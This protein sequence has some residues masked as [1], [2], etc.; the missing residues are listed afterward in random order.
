MVSITQSILFTAI[1]NTLGQAT[2]RQGFESSKINV[3]YATALSCI[4]YG[5]LGVGML[6][7]CYYTQESAKMNFNIYPVLSGLLFGLGNYF[8]VLCIYTK[9][10]LG[11]IRLIMCGFEAI[12]LFIIGY[13]VFS[14]KISYQK[15]IGAIVI[16]LGIWIAS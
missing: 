14:D 4:S 8:L 3:M 6:L 7:Y 15:I 10:P 1:P 16:L 5:I 12:L 9:E 13:L 2:L 11:M